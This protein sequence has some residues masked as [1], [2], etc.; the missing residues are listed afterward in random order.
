MN[1]QPPHPTFDEALDKIL[2]DIQPEDY[3]YAFDQDKAKQAIKEAVETH[4][5]G[6]PVEPNSANLNLHNIQEGQNRLKKV[7][8]KALYPTTR[9]K[10]K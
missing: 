10:D 6:E 3:Y 1:T 5:I 7:Q 8:L 2:Y 4:I 9:R